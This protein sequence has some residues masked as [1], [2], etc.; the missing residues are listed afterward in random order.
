M[1]TVTGKG[2]DFEPHAAGVY[3]SICIDVIDMGPKATKFGLKD[4]VRLVFATS[5]FTEV[6]GVM[7]PCVVLTTMT[8]TIGK[9]SNLRKFLEGWRGRPFTPEQLE[10]GFD[11]DDLLDV[12]AMLNIVHGASP[13]GT[14]TYAN[15]QSATR[16]P[17]GLAVPDLEDLNYVRV[18]DRTAQEQADYFKR[19][20][21]EQIAAQPSMAGKGRAAAP[22][23][24]PK[25]GKPAGGGSVAQQAAARGLMPPPEDDFSDFPGALADEDDDLP[26]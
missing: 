24:L 20:R 14:K 23:P 10:D 21:G 7:R 17:K 25:G 6:E 22:A 9:D 11:I 15:I 13:D 26:F 8:K 16:L 1:V 18:R 3:A 12:P 4:H 5:E 19:F 2:K